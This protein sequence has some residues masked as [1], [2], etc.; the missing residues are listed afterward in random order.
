MKKK[1]LIK[2][3]LDVLNFRNEFLNKK[4]QDRFSFNQKEYQILEI[5]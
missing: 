3:C 5:L 2:K 1:D 4:T